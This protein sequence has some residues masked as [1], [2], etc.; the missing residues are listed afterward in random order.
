M[1]TRNK[2]LT[3]SSSFSHLKPQTRTYQN[4]QLFMITGREKKH[5][6]INDS[7]EIKRFNNINLKRLPNS[8]RV[9]IPESNEQ[10]K[11]NHHRPFSSCK[12]NSDSSQFAYISNVDYTVKQRPLSPTNRESHDF[13]NTRHCY[14]S[15]KR[16]SKETPFTN[17][18]TTTQI[19]NLPGGV[20]RKEINDDRTH[21]ISNNSNSYKAKI[22]NDYNTNISCLPGCPYNEMKYYKE[23]IPQ[24]RQFNNRSQSDIF[25]LRS[26][27]CK[28]KY[29]PQK[30]IF[31]EKNN[32]CSAVKIKEI[33][34]IYNRNQSTFNIL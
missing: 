28:T 25:N 27:E 11:Q 19:V 34:R 21:K 12:F 10:P 26:E 29:T 18:S 23:D 4:S 16:K 22:K 17:Y 8:N 13:S 33:K 2:K 30:R 14:I 6:R 5:I 20:K 1:S 9:L 7:K 31:P 32:T 24:K 15:L 3:V